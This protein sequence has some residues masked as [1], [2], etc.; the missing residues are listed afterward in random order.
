MLV[1]VSGGS[2]ITPFISIIR[3]L[4]LV[5]NAN[6]ETPR[7]LLVAAFKK[8]VELSMLDLLLPYS[9]TCHD[10]SRLGLQIQAYVTRDT[11]PSRDGQKLPIGIWF[12]GSGSDAA[13]RGVLGWSWVGAIISSS[14]LIFLVLNALVNRY[15]NDGKT[16]I[17]SII[18]ATFVCVSVVIVGNLAL[19]WNNKQNAK[20]STQIQS[21]DTPTETELESVPEV[22]LKQ[23]TTVH[24]G[25]RPN[26]KSKL[27]KF[28]TSLFFALPACH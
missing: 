15:Y 11:Q 18:S 4:I 20:H 10:V 24:Y 9:G 7:V 13:V 25:E 2:G 16:S 17:I 14:L 22:S 21:A 19:I 6:E 28:I 27:Y 26:F 8:S 3:E 12:E 5:S 1:L 23:A